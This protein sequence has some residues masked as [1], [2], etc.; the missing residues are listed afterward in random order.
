VLTTKQLLYFDSQPTGDN[1][2]PK[3]VINLVLVSRVD[4]K[5]EESR[6][7]FNVYTPARVY[8]LRAESPTEAEA[9][10]A[11]VSGAVEAEKMQNPSRQ[12]RPSLSPIDAVRMDGIFDVDA[13]IHTTADLNMWE[14]WS[15]FDVAAWLGTFNMPM[16]G[17][18]FYRADI[19]GP[20]LTLLT[21]KDLTD[22]G[23][24]QEEQG[25]ILARIEE[26]KNPAK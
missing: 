15:K 9:W 7:R 10:I 21:A 11:A 18:K 22:L 24:P 13:R 5:G 1:S 8:K 3:G 16:N 4:G 19:D 2:N 12:R 25:D 17:V 20:K 23:I 6:E 26:L 14:S